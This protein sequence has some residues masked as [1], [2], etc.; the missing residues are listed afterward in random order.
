[1][2]QSVFSLL[3]LLASAFI[4][5]CSKDEVPLK[6]DGLEGKVYTLN[7]NVTHL[8][9]DNTKGDEYQWPNGAKLYIMFSNKAGTNEY[10][11]TAT[12]N[13]TT[14]TWSIP[15]PQGE[16]HRGDSTACKIV[17]I[18]K[19]PEGDVI[20]LTTDDIIYEDVNAKYYLGSETL[21]IR[22]TLTPKTSRI[23]FKGTAN[24]KIKVFG[25]EHYNK[26]NK[27]YNTYGKSQEELELTVQQDGYTP[28]VH[29]YFPNEARKLEITD[30]NDKI[31][32]Y[33]CSKEHLL[34]GSSWFFNIPTTT[35]LQGWKAYDRVRTYK[36]KDVEF[37]MIYVQHIDRS[38][39]LA[40][41]ETT[42][43]LWEAIDRY[44]NHAKHQAD[45]LDLPMERVTMTEINEFIYSL[46]DY[47]GVQFSLPSYDQWFFAAR[48]GIKT[49]EYKYAGSDTLSEIAWLSDN[50]NG[51]TQPVKTK[52]P[53]ELGLYDML[54]NVCEVIST[55]NSYKDAYGGD[56]ASTPTSN[57][58][59]LLNE[60]SIKRTN[61]LRN[62]EYSLY[63]GFRLCINL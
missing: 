39:Y 2:K 52:L 7:L 29:V 9:F 15:A 59:L 3:L 14:K 23:R 43:K 28:Y 11:G 5:S 33:K 10:A 54:G 32:I 8:T 34:A 26:Y 42:Q 12:Y 24:S 17:Y 55:T 56:F 62:D 61:Y 6:D 1:M 40:E 13:S 21:T 45:S 31:Y 47:L 36:V 16:L 60:G 51:T 19:A 27:E 35:N 63:I 57:A 46:R 58:I 44:P 38:F 53:N 25:I 50:S 4:C 41:T 37:K 48:G 30:S 20:N 18:N 22:T 49:M